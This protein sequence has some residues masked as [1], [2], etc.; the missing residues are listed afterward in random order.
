MSVQPSNG[1]PVV[2]P[3]KVAT[4][5]RQRSSKINKRENRRRKGDQQSCSGSDGA[6]QP[7]PVP[8]PAGYERWRWCMAAVCLLS[9]V[10][11]TLALATSGHEGHC[12]HQHPKAHEI[13]L[14]VTTYLSHV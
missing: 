11:S 4:N 13:V 9:L 6:L 3:S 5:M 14:S 2:T 10:G 7:C 1:A 12:K 8:V